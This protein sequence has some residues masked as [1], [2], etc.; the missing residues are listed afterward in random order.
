MKFWI[1][2]LCLAAL[3]AQTSE[4]PSPTAVPYTLASRPLQWRLG[5]DL[6]NAVI[7][8][9]PELNP[10][11]NFKSAAEEAERIL[12]HPDLSFGL[13]LL[14]FMKVNVRRDQLLNPQKWT[15]MGLEGRTRQRSFQG[16]G[17]FMGSQMTTTEG[18]YHLV[19]VAAMPGNPFMAVRKEASGEN[20]IF[21]F[22]GPLKTKHVRTKFSETKWENSLYEEC[23]ADHQSDT[24]G[25]KQLRVV[26]E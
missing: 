3:A 22:A 6:G 8:E 2:I 15:I 1:P 5:F 14:P 13:A 26:C 11:N 24:E 10:E 18:G 16:I 25:V 9:T 20:L 21:G 4:P 12:P 23:A 7:L 19:S 17:L